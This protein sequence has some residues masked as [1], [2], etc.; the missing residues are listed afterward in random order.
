MTT[1]EDILEGDEYEELTSD[2]NDECS[3]SPSGQTPRNFQPSR[4]D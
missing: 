4:K 1:S 3:S 2:S